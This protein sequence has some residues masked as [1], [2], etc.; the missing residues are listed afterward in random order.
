M[1]EPDIKNVLGKFL[2]GYLVSAILQP[3]EQEKVLFCP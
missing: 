1:D 3:T 2:M